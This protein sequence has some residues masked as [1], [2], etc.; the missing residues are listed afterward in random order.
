M[1]VQQ[2]TFERGNYQIV[3]EN[4]WNLPRFTQERI[5]VNGV[6]VRDCIPVRITYLFWRTMFEDTI[7]NKDGEQTLL[8]QWKSGLKTVKARVLID[9]EH[10][11][12]TKAYSEKW[13]GPRGEWPEDA[14]YEA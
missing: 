9:G 4:A 12:W 2:W 5:T 8:V 13:T 6:K 7:L 14:F 3:V 11:A 10:V 1:N